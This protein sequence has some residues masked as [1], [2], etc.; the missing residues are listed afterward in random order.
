[1]LEC[2]ADILYCFRAY[3][4][5]AVVHSIEEQFEI[6]LRLVVVVIATAGNDSVALQRWFGIN[7]AVVHILG[8]ARLKRVF[9]A[10]VGNRGVDEHLVT[11][12]HDDVVEQLLHVVHL[13][14]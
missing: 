3:P 4:H 13:M 6:Y 11:V 2:H 9:R 12:Y 8:A 14:C 5:F 1:M 10:D 7:H